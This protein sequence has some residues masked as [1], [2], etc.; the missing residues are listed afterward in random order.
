MVALLLG[1]MAGL[2]A[3]SRQGTTAV[4]Q[5]L[6]AYRRPTELANLYGQA[7]AQ[8]TDQQTE[9]EDLRKRVADYEAA[10]G[11][12]SNL[13]QVMSE[14]LAQHRA[15]LGLVALHGPG[16]V[17][18]LDDSS[19][20]SRPEGVELAPLLVN[21]TDLVMIINEL[22]TAG[23]EAIAINDEAIGPR[24]SIRQS[25]PM[26]YCNNTPINSPFRIVALGD[27]EKLRTNLEFPGGVLEQLRSLGQTVT[28]EV[29]RDLEVPALRLTP[30][31]ELARPVVAAGSR[32]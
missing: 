8:L 14:E 24:P 3:A 7:Q 26:M 10:V 16:I 11:A 28:L 5:P 15:E 19:L 23:A 25:G 20:R 13:A 9:I 6:G 21:Q 2:L 1:V 29:A 12:R 18:T 32:R 31:L 30:K 17:L 27:G 22:W 4:E